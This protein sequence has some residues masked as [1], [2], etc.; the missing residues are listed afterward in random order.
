MADLVVEDDQDNKYIVE[1]DRAYTS[2]FLYKA[3]FNTSR[4]VIDSLSAQEN[5]STIKKIFH[6][7][8]LYF[9]SDNMEQSLYHGKTLFK[10]LGE[11]GPLDIHISDLGRE[12]I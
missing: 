9:V 10:G 2:S 8:L 6:V 12:D 11:S 5:Y 7:N 4:L 1:I 3:C